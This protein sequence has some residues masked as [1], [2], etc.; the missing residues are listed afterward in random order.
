MK[1]PTPELELQQREWEKRVLGAAGD[2]STLRASSAVAKGGTS[3]EPQPDGSFI[4]NGE[5]PRRQTY[6]IQAPVALPQVTGVRIEALPHST[7]PRSG[8]GRDTYGNFVLTELTVELNDGSGWRPVTFKRTL[9]DDGKVEDARTGQ[10]WKIDASREDN[11]LARQFVLT[12]EPPL[13][14][15]PPAQLRISLHQ[16]SD[17]IGQS[18]G[19]FRLSVTG[20][21]DPSWIVQVGAK[22][23]GMLEAA[24]RDPAASKDLAAFFRPVTPSLAQERAELKRLKKGLDNMKV[25]TALVV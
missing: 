16:N 10:L 23:R 4:A 19:R 15:A 1:T 2:W 6:V 9:A 14:L 12:F 3:L 17:L 21:K 18:I 5:N 25:T 20:A 24:T 11:R 7:L 22:Q 13:K 8:P